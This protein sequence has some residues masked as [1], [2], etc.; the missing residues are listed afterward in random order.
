MALFKR[1]NTGGVRLNPQELRNALYPS[2]FNELLF[3]LARTDTFRDTWRMPRYTSEEDE[4]VPKKLQ[5]NAL[6]KTMADCELVLRFFAIKE[7][8]LQDR[9]GSLRTLMNKTMVNHISDSEEQLI[10]L[11][12]GFRNVLDFFFTTFEGH[13][14][15]LPNTNRPSR[16]AYDALM[17]A[18]SIVGIANLDGRQERIRSN[19]TAAASQRKQ[20]EIL[21]GRGNTVEAIRERVSLAQQ[22]LKD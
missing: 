22:I 16:P 17:V 10:G 15:V 14:F 21:V 11:D 8:V 2:K 18:G 7:T 5:F 9:R 13:P 3:V 12:E 19:F 4:A 6:Y 20:Y 1:L